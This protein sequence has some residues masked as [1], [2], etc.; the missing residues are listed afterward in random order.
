[1]LLATNYSAECA[2]NCP[3]SPNFA[4]IYPKTIS[5]RNYEIPPKIEILIFKKEK[6]KLQYIEEEPNFQYNTF[7]HVFFIVKILPLYVNFNIPPC[8]K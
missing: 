8:G 4:K 1:M 2:Q 5:L 3:K 7:S 6:E